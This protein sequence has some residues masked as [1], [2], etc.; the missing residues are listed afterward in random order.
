MTID[1]CFEKR[2]R[3]LKKCFLLLAIGSLVIAAG[4]SS[5][6]PTP[7]NTEGGGVQEM[8]IDVDSGI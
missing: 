4:C 3:V 6:T 5:G 8:E 2:I 1:E 7:S